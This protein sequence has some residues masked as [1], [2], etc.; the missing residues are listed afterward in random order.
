MKR[1]ITCTLEIN[2]N[3]HQLEAKKAKI[4]EL[5]GNLNPDT[6]GISLG[7][8]TAFDEITG[9]TIKTDTVSPLNNGYVDVVGTR[10]QMV[11][12]WP[13]HGELAVI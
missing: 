5:S 13:Y 8:T 10:F 6:S 11:D 4:E 12:Y 2:E 1:N 3:F 9:E 7:A